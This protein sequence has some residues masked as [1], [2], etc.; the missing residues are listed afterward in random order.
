MSNNTINQ[1]QANLAQAQ[2]ALRQ[3][4]YQ[5]GEV[6]DYEVRRLERKCSE[7]RAAIDAAIAARK[8]GAA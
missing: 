5:E 3:W 8:G 7:L 6:A 2:E 4:E 1:L